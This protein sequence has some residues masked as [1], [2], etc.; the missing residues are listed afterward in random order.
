VPLLVA[1]REPTSRI[2]RREINQLMVKYKEHLN[3]TQAQLDTFLSRDEYKAFQLM[4]KNQQTRAQTAKTVL[5]GADGLEDDSV[6]IGDLC[7]FFVRSLCVTLLECM[8]L[9]PTLGAMRKFTQSLQCV[10]AVTDEMF[11]QGLDVARARALFD[12]ADSDGSG[13]ISRS[14]L[15]SMIKQFKVPITK[16]DFRTIFRT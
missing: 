9:S 16:K 13:D 3:V 4:T 8:Q 7:S 5:I 15:Y 11:Q 6:E 12:M 1:D 10:D 2:D 14:E